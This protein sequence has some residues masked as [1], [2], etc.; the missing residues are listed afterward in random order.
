MG[1][2][3]RCSDYA[4]QKTEKKIE[5]TPGSMGRVRQLAGNKGQQ[6]IG[7]KSR[8]SRRRDAEGTR[9][10]LQRDKQR[11]KAEKFA[12]VQRRKKSGVWGREKGETKRRGESARMLA[13]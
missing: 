2:P 7:E 8:G 10:R 12:H 6:K 3:R 13:G 9:T 1:D 4:K 11:K 5:L